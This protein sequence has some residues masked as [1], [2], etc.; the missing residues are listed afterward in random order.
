[1]IFGE[2]SNGS[3]V[4]LFFTFWWILSFPWWNFVR[5]LWRI[6]FERE[7]LINLVEW[8]W[9]KILNFNYIYITKKIFLGEK[10]HYL[11]FSWFILIE[12]LGCSSSI[13]LLFFFLLL[14]Y[15]GIWAG[16]QGSNYFQKGFFLLVLRWLSYYCQLI[17]LIF[18]TNEWW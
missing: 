11:F 12:N 16:K 10:I 5:E 13:F 17:H 18:E 15:S 6:T 7:V 1:M 2:V 9:S 14:T 3:Q 8:I 4:K